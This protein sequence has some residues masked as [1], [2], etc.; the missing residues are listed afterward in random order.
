MGAAASVATEHVRLEGNKQF[1]AGEYG[2]AI[3]TWTRAIC[4]SDDDP[5]LFSNRSQGFLKLGR[6]VDALLDAEVAALRQPGWAK[7]HFRMG[8]ALS[9]MGEPL[10]AV[11][12][13]RRAAA[14]EPHDKRVR[15]ALDESEQR[16]A[17]CEGG[18][19]SGA[20]AS[21]YTWGASGSA[22]ALLGRVVDRRD[23]PVHTAGAVTALDGLQL[24]DAACGSAHTVVLS[25][26]GEVYAW[27]LNA[28]GQCG[29]DGQHFVGAPALL[30]FSVRE[31]VSAIGC[32]AAH[33][34]A[35]TSE[36][37]AFAW[38]SGAEGQLGLGEGDD[39]GRATPCAI[40]ALGSRARGAAA[41][42][43]C[44][45]A[46]HTIVLV[47][48]DTLFSFGRNSEGQLGIDPSTANGDGARVCAPARVALPLG[49]GAVRH[50]AASA[51]HTAIVTAR[52]TVYTMGSSARGALGL[53][54]GVRCARAPRA[55][56]VAAPEDGA[57]TLPRIAST[58][59]GDGFTLLLGAD[60]S[61]WGFGANDVGQLGLGHGG[62]ADVW[63]PT[64]LA[65]L[66]GR[67]VDLV[68]CV[69]NHVTAVT[70]SGEVLAWGQ[71]G[72]GRHVSNRPYV[73]EIDLP[74]TVLPTA[75][76][77]SG[78]S[79]DR[80]AADGARGA[81][82]YSATAQLVERL[83]CGEAHS[84]AVAVAFAPT[85]CTLE[86]TRDGVPLVAARDEVAG[87]RAGERAAEDGVLECSAG[88]AIELT[89]VGANSRCERVRTGGARFF[90]ACTSDSGAPSGFRVALR[91]RGDGT[92]VCTLPLDAAG[93]YTLAVRSGDG[94]GAVHVDGSPLRLRVAALR[95][96]DPATSRVVLRPPSVVVCG[97]AVEVALQLRD[98]Y[99]NAVCLDASGAP[100]E[101]H[102]ACFVDLAEPKTARAAV[103]IAVMPCYRYDDDEGAATGTGPG[104]G[105]GNGNGNGPGTGN[106]NGNGNGKGK[107]NGSTAKGTRGMARFR[108]ELPCAARFQVRFTVG[109]LA[110]AGR[111]GAPCDV[112]A[113]AAPAAAAECMLVAP[114]ADSYAAL[115]STVP[116][117]V[118]R[119]GGGG[120][121]AELRLAAGVPYAL[122]LVLRD[123]FGNDAPLASSDVE[124]ALIGAGGGCCAGAKCIVLCDPGERG[125]N[126]A[127]L[128]I[129]GDAVALLPSALRVRVNG[130]VVDAWQREADSSEETRDDSR[131]VD[132][133]G[134]A[135]RGALAV[136]FEPGAPFAPRCVLRERR[137]SA[138]APE[139]IV[140]T[141]D[142]GAS[143]VAR[144]H[145][146]LCDR[147]GNAC[148]R[149]GD[150]ALIDVRVT[151]AG[152]E[153][154]GGGVATANVVEASGGE[155]ILKLTA[156]GAGVCVVRVSVDEISVPGSPFEWALRPDPA[157]S[158]RDAAAAAAEAEEE[159]LR[160]F[161]ERLR[162]ELEEKRAKR[163]AE[164]AQR[165]AVERE[166]RAREAVALRT[167]EAD[168][169][170]ERDRRRAAARD[171]LGEERAAR[172]RVAAAA[173]EQQ[174]LERLRREETTRNRSRVVLR[175]TR[176]RKVREEEAAAEK[177]RNQRRTG[178]GWTARFS[179]TDSAK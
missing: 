26:S 164:N 172:E 144:L 159:E 83:E 61:V 40:E 50:I 128:R 150:G 19:R 65:S 6:A 147:F 131:E 165:E 16:A 157:A 163:E 178:G 102:C 24:V 77:S 100:A 93:E 129:H 117:R 110:L 115:H 63:A 153:G 151:A 32:G 107:G 119:A 145:L 20:S 33:C 58:T 114:A 101:E 169:A 174:Q 29:F 4:I 10:A 171:V 92:Y 64:R 70:R 143:A 23:A 90:A 34:I 124:A 156:R 15:A 137:T 18:A 46:A 17:L 76:A 52:G 79:G 73:W 154:H 167:A 54:A 116:R 127:A 111:D 60:R 104:P 106:G 146:A 21:A 89:V 67:G 86:A 57:R 49:G 42:S 162:E 30:A 170:A 5:R 36:G 35:L 14:L 43:V 51:R 125:A 11:A 62:T 68:G 56:T 139:S 99:S 94:G 47:E 1:A 91:D 25:I 152:F 103:D 113:V 84:L 53:G 168:F 112:M 166:G 44:C 120:K 179:E 37:K 175:K 109:G 108:F 48:G 160:R 105:T 140:S 87:E 130:E 98:R 27:G 149:G 155:Y 158:A 132:Q 41:R 78:G 8:T 75:A 176:R 95:V 72:K 133:G 177:L 45:G 28:Q 9:A 96:A 141:L 97:K 31:C 123:R 173:R 118:V 161:E 22:A 7:A 142:G 138:R 66:D 88:D 122:R 135:W 134:A 71:A 38:G 85:F 69:G 121:G 59:C 2:A 81:Q 74:R 12:S 3:A 136:T 39:A 82:R 80:A 55:V 126:V 148:A 13:L